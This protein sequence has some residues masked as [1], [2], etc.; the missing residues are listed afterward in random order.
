MSVYNTI[1]FTNVLKLL[2]ELDLPKSRVADAAGISVSYFSDMTNGKANPTLEI[3]E[4][5]ACSLGVDLPFLLESTDMD[6]ETLG[7]LSNNRPHSLGL[8]PGYERVCVV[9][10]SQQAFIAK[11]WAQEARKKLK[12]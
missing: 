4:A 8:P 7:T 3:M 11:K 6:A 1:F 2:D 12:K 5:I 9:L 10:P